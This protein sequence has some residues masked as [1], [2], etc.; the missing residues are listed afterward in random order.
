MDSLEVILPI[1]FVALFPFEWIFI[2]HLISR[3]A[4]FPRLERDYPVPFGYDGCLH[5]MQSG[6]I[7]KV[8]YSGALVIGISDSGLYLRPGKFFGLFTLPILLPWNEL[9]AKA[10]TMFRRDVAVL[11]MPS[12]PGESFIFPQDTY[13]MMEPYLGP[14]TKEAD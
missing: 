6:R 4:G 10:N 2:T 11:T 9:E 8:R 3:R 12:R 7:N 13:A 14:L 5:L 1:V